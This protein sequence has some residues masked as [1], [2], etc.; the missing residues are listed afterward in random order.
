[1]TI[2][3]FAGTTAASVFYSSERSEDKL[4][5]PPHVLA[6]LLALAIEGSTTTKVSE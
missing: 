2:P 5:T 3:L 6:N 1:M 4:V